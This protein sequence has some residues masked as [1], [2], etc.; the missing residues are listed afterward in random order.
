MVSPVSKIAEI[1]VILSHKDQPGAPIEYHGSWLGS[2]EL[3]GKCEFSVDVNWFAGTVP[4]TERNWKQR[5]DGYC[6]NS[7]QYLSRHYIR[8]IAGQ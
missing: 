2:D 6:W 7:L 3:L 5:G 1:I 8:S 4:F